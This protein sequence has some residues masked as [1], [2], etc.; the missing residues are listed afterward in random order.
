MSDE[1]AFLAHEDGDAV[2]VAVRDVEP[3][4]GSLAVLGA[5]S[6]RQITVAESIPLGHKI[7]LVDLA[8]GAQVVE[9]GEPIGLASQGIKAGELVHVHNIRSTKW[10]LN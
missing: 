2:A 9:Y 5:D 4:T 1:L 8:E 10:Q 6:R 7:A 3:G